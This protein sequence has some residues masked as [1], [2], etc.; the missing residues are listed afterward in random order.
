MYGMDGLYEPPSVIIF[1]SH[2]PTYIISHTLRASQLFSGFVNNSNLPVFD[3]IQYVIHNIISLSHIEQQD[4][5][6][7]SIN[8]TC[9]YIPHNRYIIYIQVI[10]YGIIIIS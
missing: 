1:E 5:E 7:S 10:R 6:E 8:T 4:G 2:A 3:R 9:V